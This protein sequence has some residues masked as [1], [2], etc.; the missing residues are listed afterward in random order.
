VQ[1]QEVSSESYCPWLFSC[2]TAFFILHIS[3]PFVKFLREILSLF[4]ASA[5]MGG[6]HAKGEEGDTQQGSY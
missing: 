2:L 6:L 3:A 1:H 4:F 5:A